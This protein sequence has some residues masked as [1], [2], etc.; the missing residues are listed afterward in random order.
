MTFTGAFTSTKS[1]YCTTRFRDPPP[2]TR[3]SLMLDHSIKMIFK[4]A[5]SSDSEGTLGILNQ[6]NIDV[7]S[8]AFSIIDMVRLYGWLHWLHW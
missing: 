7:A 2:V 6:L 1:S 4:G 5:V 3:A 8:T